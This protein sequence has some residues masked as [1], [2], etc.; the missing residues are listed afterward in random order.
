MLAMPVMT[1]AQKQWAFDNPHRFNRAL[2]SCRAGS[3][4]R[5]PLD[6]LEACGLAGLHGLDSQ[7][8]MQ[9]TD[10]TV[11]TDGDTDVEPTPR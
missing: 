4:Y 2:L 3:S 8:I 7:E 9:I 11:F 1:D 10:D 6:D 5:V